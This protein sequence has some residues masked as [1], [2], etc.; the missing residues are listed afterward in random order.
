MSQGWSAQL[1][2]LAI[3]APGITYSRSHT[4]LKLLGF[5]EPETSRILKNMVTTVIKHNY[6]SL[7][8]SLFRAHP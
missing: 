4:C 3:A 8:S 6:K 1:N 2:T 5:N 7:A